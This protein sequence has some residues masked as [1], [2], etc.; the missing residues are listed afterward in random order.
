MRKFNRR[1]RIRKKRTIIIITILI[2][3]V[4]LAPVYAYM[5]K[6]LSLE[7]T[8][9]IITE[10][11][12]KSCDGII[13]YTTNSWQSGNLNY[14]HFSFTLTN[15]GGKDFNFWEIYFDVPNDSE[16]LTYSSSEVSLV[17][18]KLMAQNVS[19]NGTILPTNS[20]TFEVQMSTSEENYRPTNIVI[21]NCYYEDDDTE[22][23]PNDD[24][25]GPLDIKFVPVASYGNYTFQYDVTVTNTSTLTINE[26]EFAI[27]KLENT[28][29]N[30]IWNA[31]Y[32]IKEDS[33]ILSNMTYNG[34]ISPGD[35][36][37]FGIIIDTD[38]RNFKP[39]V[40]S[41]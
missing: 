22:E 23:N 31:N 30:N 3:I 14:Y 15:N 27:E 18:T 39:K 35:S 38:K 36:I 16:I 32:I 26:W 33:I 8:A 40:I 17:G 7:G 12:K 21:N 9:T 41:N 34:T 6:Q 13:T 11:T 19:Y 24:I 37:T 4:F 20:V 2:S 10:D 25:N 5:R 28:K 1:N 29:I